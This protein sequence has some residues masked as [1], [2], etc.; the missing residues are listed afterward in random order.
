MD[1]ASSCP[2]CSP[3]DSSVAP[4]L[5]GP[6]RAPEDDRAFG[7][8]LFEAE[9]NLARGAGQKALVLASRAVKE[10]PDSLTARALMDRARRELLRGRR[11]DKLEARLQEAQVALEKGDLKTAE[12]IILSALKVVP[13]FA[14]AQELFK[15]LKRARAAQGSVEAEAER[16]LAQ[17]AEDQVRR[18]VE[19]A[20]AAQGAGWEAKAL[21]SIRRGLRVVPDAP[22]LLG[23]LSETQRATEA[24]DVDRARRHALVSQV[25]AGLELLRRGQI[26]ESLKIL[27][28][29]LEED[30][31][32]A[33]AQ[34]AIQ[35][36]RR[37]WLA[38]SQA[39]VSLTA[40]QTSGGTPARQLR[41]VMDIP[42]A[43][44]L[45]RPL[46]SDS[47]PPLG[48]PERDRGIPGEIRLPR[49]LRRATPLSL[50]LGGGAVVIIVLFFALDRGSSSPPAPTAAPSTPSLVVRPAPVP[51]IAQNEGPLK[52][53]DPSLRAAIQRTVVDYAHALEA[54]DSDLLRRTRPD[55]GPEER[56]R[57]LAPFENALNAAT[58]VRVLDVNAHGDVAEVPILRTDLIVGRS[59]RATPPTE[60]TL[61][62]ERRKGAWGVR[63]RKERG[64]P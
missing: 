48:E 58:D 2:R 60:E 32:N 7:L 52:D 15:R 3:P 54:H 20:R 24:R 56:A 50:I 63:P 47:F 1:E 45:A 18:A 27:R 49:T 41:G 16:E 51:A 30:P 9:E 64:G 42:G 22:E 4:F 53:V 12:R 14:L 23:M 5:E 38:R 43:V 25:R 57:L 6:T 19:A 55:L 10:R 11:R 35:E 17:L 44:V 13:D 61:R 28:A 8:L 37:A 39:P 33:R 26:G 59:A 21:L 36:V 34:A 31:E 46:G 40:T 29:A 62:F